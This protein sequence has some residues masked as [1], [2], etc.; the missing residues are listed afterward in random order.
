MDSLT[1]NYSSTSTSS[2]SSS[3]SNTEPEAAANETAPNPPTRPTTAPAA[4][5]AS[6]V[7][8]SPTP[9]DDDDDDSADGFEVIS[10][11]PAA[12]GSEIESRK[13]GAQSAEDAQKS[14]LETW[15]SEALALREST[16]IELNQAV[17]KNK[18]FRNPS[19]LQKMIAYC[20]IDEHASNI[21]A[22]PINPEDCYDAIAERQRTI[23]EG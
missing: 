15:V 8:R 23:A 14:A 3:P 17:R 4:S 10:V 13:R 9:E 20:G 21:A 22:P 1:A 18:N 2:S 6:S 5:G 12:N 11:K 19:I 7:S 16:G